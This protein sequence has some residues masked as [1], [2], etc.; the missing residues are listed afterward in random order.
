MSAKLFKSKIRWVLFLGVGG[1][2]AWAILRTTAADP[3]PA[4]AAAGLVIQD[5]FK[6]WEKSGPSGAFYEWQKDGLM[7]GTA[8]YTALSAYFRRLDRALGGYKSYDIV[9]T[10]NVG[11]RSQIVY[12]AINFER[13]AMYARFVLY[14]TPKKCVVQNMDFSPKPEAVMPWLAFQ[15][16][17][18]SE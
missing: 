4:P 2:V 13:T 8:K 3:V 6:L 1:I 11:E 7:E 16:V 15:E 9:E 10:K 17:N 14:Q 5:G 12:L 18:Y